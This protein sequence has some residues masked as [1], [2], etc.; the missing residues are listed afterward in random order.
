VNLSKT[1]DF[2]D[3]AQASQLNLCIWEK[4]YYPTKATKAERYLF[5][6]RV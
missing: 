3:N 6:Y 5:P 2:D 4:R 1:G